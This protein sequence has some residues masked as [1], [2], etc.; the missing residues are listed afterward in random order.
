VHEL[1]IAISLVDAVCDELPRLGNRVN[2]RRVLVRIGP[3]SG[4]VPDAL[5]F[6]FDVAVE[7]TPIAGAYLDVEEVAGNALELKAVE[8]VDGSENR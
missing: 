5:Q 4:V 7:G 3:L 8:V 6:A 2:V 1:S